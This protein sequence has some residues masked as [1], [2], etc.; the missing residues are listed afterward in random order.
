MRGGVKN[1]R[2]STTAAV[3]PLTPDHQRDGQRHQSEQE[4]GR[5]TE[6]RAADDQHRAE[7]VAH[8]G[9]PPRPDLSVHAPSTSALL[10]TRKAGQGRHGGVAAPTRSRAVTG[11]CRASSRRSRASGRRRVET[12]AEDERLPDGA[13]GPLCDSTQTRRFMNAVAG[14]REEAA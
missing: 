8:R 4:D 7:H 6:D 1:L 14:R 2:R 10:R 5:V 11:V 13:A 3:H 9:Q 12:W